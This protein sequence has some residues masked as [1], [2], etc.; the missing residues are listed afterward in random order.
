[1][2]VLADHPHVVRVRLSGPVDARIEQA[3]RRYGLSIDEARRQQREN[4]GARSNWVQR[5][6]GRD[7]TDPS[8]Y[9]VVINATKFDVEECVGLI[10]AASASV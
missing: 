1:M 3:V 4:D 5:F 2:L 6:Y 10:V 9:D 7:V 8:L